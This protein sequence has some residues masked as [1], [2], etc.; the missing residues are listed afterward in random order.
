MNQTDEK[1]PISEAEKAE[2]RRTVMAMSED[3]K[4]TAL[5]VI[6][7]VMLM[8]ELKVRYDFL[9]NFYIRITTESDTMRGYP[10]PD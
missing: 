6:P 5:E 7:D 8:D 10:T 2:I 3:Q 9:A 4:K 1:R